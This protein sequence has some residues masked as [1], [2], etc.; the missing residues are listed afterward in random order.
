MLSST[1]VPPTRRRRCC[2]SAFGGNAVCLDVLLLKLPSGSFFF[3]LQKASCSGVNSDDDFHDIIQNFSVYVGQTIQY[4][5]HKAEEISNNL[6]YKS[7]W[8]QT[9]A[10]DGTA[11]PAWIIAAF[12]TCGSSI[13]WKVLMDCKFSYVGMLTRIWICLFQPG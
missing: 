11:L 8:H 4:Q 9:A 7:C 2:G 6:E 3:P 10:P 12:L 13:H 5:K 1:A